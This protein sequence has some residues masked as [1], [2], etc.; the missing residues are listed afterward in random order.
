MEGGIWSAVWSLCRTEARLNFRIL[1]HGFGS[2]K[3]LLFA[4]TEIVSSGYL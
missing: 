3:A 1:G 2:D 4:I